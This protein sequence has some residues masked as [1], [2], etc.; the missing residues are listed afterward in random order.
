MKV[1]TVL[2]IM[3]LSIPA[4][5]N[6]ICKRDVRIEKYRTMLVERIENIALHRWE[7]VENYIT[8]RHSIKFTRFC[9][10]KKCDDIKCKSAGKKI[11]IVI[12]YDGGL[13]INNNIIDLSSYKLTKRLKKI[14][15]KRLCMERHPDENFIIETLQFLNAW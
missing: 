10:Y 15:Y 7:Y 5:A 4:F 12:F 3:L 13:H 8:G 2:I 1:V 11:N 9:K 6:H 14:Y